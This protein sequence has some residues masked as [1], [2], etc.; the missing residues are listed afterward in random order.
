MM[1]AKKKLAEIIDDMQDAYSEEEDHDFFLEK[2]EDVMG[3]FGAGI[4]SYFSLI[5]I[6]ADF[7]VIASL[8]CIPLLIQFSSWK[9]RDDQFTA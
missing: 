1:Q 3:R 4:V 6:S 2:D 7:L 5:R 9:H 8:L